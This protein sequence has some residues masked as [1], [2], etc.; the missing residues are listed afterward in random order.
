MLPLPL[1]LLL[2][3][4]VTGGAVAVACCWDEVREWALDRACTW[5]RRH[6]GAPAEDLLREVIVELDRVVVGARRAVRRLFARD[7]QGRVREVC[8]EEVPL[9]DLPEDIR[10]TL[11]HQGLT[12]AWEI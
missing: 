9:E 1:L 2:G 12:Q 6:L 5:C 8:T 4:A 10:H 11:H 7:R 3:A